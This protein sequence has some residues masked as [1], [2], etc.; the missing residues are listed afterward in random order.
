MNHTSSSAPAPGPASN[1]TTLSRTIHR[2]A[3]TSLEIDTSLPVSPNSYTPHTAAI[4]SRSAN[5]SGENR[6]PLH[7]TRSA[8]ISLPLGFPMSGASA[9]LSARRRPTNLILT[10]PTIPQHLQHSNASL[11]PK[12][13]TV[14]RLSFFNNNSIPSAGLAPPSAFL[15]SPAESPNNTAFSDNY[16]GSINDGLE[17][18]EVPNK[19][20]YPDGPVEVCGNGIFLYSEPS[21]AIASNF[22]VVINVAREVPNPFGGRTNAN[23]AH[24]H[25]GC[26]CETPVQGT[27]PLSPPS[28]PG[29]DSSSP[30]SP[31]NI[32]NP[33]QQPIPQRS[34]CCTEL[35]ESKDAYDNSL[36]EYVFVPWDHNSKLIP[37]LPY[38]TALI[39]RRAEEGKRVLV[40]CQCG[41]SRSASLVVAYVMK[42]QGLDLNTAY[43]QVKGKAP[44]IGPNM[45]LIY[46]LMEWGRILKGANPGELLDGD[47]DFVAAPN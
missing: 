1:P 22:D 25:A 13:A 19:T 6:P 39:A 38:L 30:I 47:E 3:A 18:S 24:A 33:Q 10:L 20:S 7:P 11:P 36:P 14:D 31:M 4:P 45:N 34:S 21:I 5:Q 42:E 43:A 35:H 17:S 27:L 12:S 8:S 9:S 46:Q 44:A 16:F 26:N 40:H 37:D 2:R 23:H 29:S 32:F 15:Y 28:L 41:V